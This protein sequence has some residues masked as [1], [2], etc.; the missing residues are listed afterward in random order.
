[1]IFSN[2]SGFK[3]ISPAL[4]DYTADSRP[5]YYDWDE[6]VMESN[7]INRMDSSIYLIGKPVNFNCSH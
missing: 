4:C 7:L 2:S 5:M 1:M 6:A 3:D